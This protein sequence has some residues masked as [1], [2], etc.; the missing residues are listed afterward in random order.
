MDTLIKAFA[1][2]AETARSV[3]SLANDLPPEVRAISGFER[4][5]DS[6]TQ[7]MAATVVAV[8]FYDKLT[9]RLGYVRYSLSALALFVCN[10]AQS[11]ERNQW[12]RLF[13][14]LQRLVSHRRGT[15]TVSA[16][17]GWRL[18]ARRESTV[19]AGHG[20]RQSH[21]QVRSSCSEENAPTANSRQDF[22]LAALREPRPRSYRTP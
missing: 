5:L 8:Q 12:R 11:A 13:T 4:Q 1:G 9:Q 14:S 16:H 10:P 19:A 22:A 6:M 18:S 15:A 7:Q 3:R 17:A 2:L 20:A 21:R